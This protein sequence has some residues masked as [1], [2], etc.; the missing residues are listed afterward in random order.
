[1]TVAVDNIFTAGELSETH[2]SASVHLL[3]GYANL[4]AQSEFAAVGETGGGVYIYCGRVNTA[5]EA[6]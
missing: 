6:L 5:E 2:G 1:M 4:G 3:C